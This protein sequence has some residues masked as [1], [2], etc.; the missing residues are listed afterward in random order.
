MNTIAEEAISKSKV[1][2][3]PRRRDDTILLI[4]EVAIDTRDR[5]LNRVTVI[6]KITQE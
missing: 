6:F 5:N 3:A 1:R 4:K 2:R